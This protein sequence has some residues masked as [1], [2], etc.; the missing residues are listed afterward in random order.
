MCPVSYIL[1]WSETFIENKKKKKCCDHCN[2][3]IWHWITG[4][5]ECVSDILSFRSNP[6]F[7]PVYHARVCIYKDL[8]SVLFWCLYEL[9]VSFLLRRDCSVWNLLLLSFLIRPSIHPRK[10]FLFSKWTV[11]FT[12]VLFLI[13][14]KSFIT[15]SVNSPLLCSVEESHHTKLK[16]IHPY[17][18]LQTQVLGVCILLIWYELQFVIGMI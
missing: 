3:F 14:F 12:V 15:S 18:V 2:L 11:A 16:S 13:N 1:L 9:K 6:Y 8:E 10:E 5:Q 4:E 7:K 17:F